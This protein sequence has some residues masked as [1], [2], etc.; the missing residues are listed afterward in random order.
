MDKGNEESST[1]QEF[2]FQ[3]MHI[4]VT[5]ES[6]SVCKPRCSPHTHYPLTLQYC[7]PLFAHKCCPACPSN[8]SHFL[9]DMSVWVGGGGRDRVVVFVIPW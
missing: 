4:G 5:G 9:S 8:A 3:Q 1:S 6:E 7:E 2:Y